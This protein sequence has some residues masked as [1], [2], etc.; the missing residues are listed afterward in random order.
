MADDRRAFDPFA[1][2]PATHKGAAKK[3]PEGAVTKGSRRQ[4]TP[5]PAEETAQTEPETGSAD[6]VDTPTK[7]TGGRPKHRKERA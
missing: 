1:P 6:A 7:Q 2:P 3:D 5:V 4:A